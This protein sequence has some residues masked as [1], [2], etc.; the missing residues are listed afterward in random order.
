MRY[1][2]FKK[3]EHG[4]KDFSF[5]V[6]YRSIEREFKCKWDFI[7]EERFYDLAT[8]LQKRIDGTA[9]GKN[10]KSKG[11]KRYSTFDEFLDQIKR[12]PLS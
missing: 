4:I 8:Y 9:L 2:E 3:A 10:L 11:Q 12:P 7:P 5:A 1:N 6:I